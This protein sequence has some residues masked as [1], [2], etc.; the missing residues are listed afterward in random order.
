[1]KKERYFRPGTNCLGRKVTTWWPSQR[2]PNIFGYVS[3]S[4]R[5]DLGC[6]CLEDNLEIFCVSEFS[7]PKGVMG[8][9]SGAFRAETSH[10]R[11]ACC[12]Q[13]TSL[14]PV[15]LDVGEKQ[16]GWK[17]EVPPAEGVEGQCC[18]RTDLEAGLPFPGHGCWWGI[19]C[20]SCV[21]NT[22]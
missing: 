20:P 6:S 8:P 9:S 13:Q 15:H 11:A 19:A 2:N 12:Y 5:N 18:R 4:D 17:R 1:M 21:V 22:P 3:V 14:P 7:W 16:E 10:L